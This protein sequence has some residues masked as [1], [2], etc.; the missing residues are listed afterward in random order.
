MAWT[1]GGR[2]R[3]GSPWA[4]PRREEP[5]PGPPAHRLLHLSPMNTMPSK[6]QRAP[7]AGPRGSGGAWRSTPTPRNF[8]ATSTASSPSGAPE[9]L[10]PASRRDFLRLMG[11]SLALAGVGH[12]PFGLRLRRG[13]AREVLPYVRQPENIVQGKPLQY[14]TALSLNG[15]GDGRPGREPHGPADDGRGEREAPRQPRRDRLP[16]PVVAPHLYDPDRSQ[17]VMHGKL[18]GS[19]DAFLL[20]AVSALDAVRPKKGAG[21]RLLTETVT[22]P[23]LAR[24]IR[25]LLKEF[26]EAKWHQYDPAGT[27]LGQ[28]RRSSSRS[29]ATCRSGYDLGEGR[30]DRLP[31]RRLPRLRLSRRPARWPAAFGEPARAR[32]RPG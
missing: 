20:A 17:V 18:I 1:A 19:F 8:S 32:S 25:A 27:A 9:W 28:G 10:D 3:A 30:R 12:R 31:R 29:A 5:Y 26:P 23:T 13:P 2:G 6:N 7:P 11:A 24:Q 16:H 21:L 14:A 15:F 22:S 4:R